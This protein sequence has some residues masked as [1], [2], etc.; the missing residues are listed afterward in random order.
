MKLSRRTDYALRAVRNIAGLPKGT[1]G[2]IKGIA[3]AESLPPNFLA[4]ILKDLTFAGIL[5]SFHGITG[6]YRLARPPKKITYLEVIEAMEGPMHLS[7]C[8]GAKGCACRKD[9]KSRLHQFW[10]AQEQAVRNALQKKHFGG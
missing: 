9:D 10:V 1:L 4:K 6:G 2:T 8:T 3:Q 5:S 7:L